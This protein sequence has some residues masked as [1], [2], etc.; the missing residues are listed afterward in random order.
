MM[1]TLLIAIGNRLR[2]DDGVAHQ[3]VALLALPRC[4]QVHSVHQLTPELGEEIAGFDEVVFVDAASSETQNPSVEELG[5]GPVCPTLGHAVSPSAVVTLA[6]RLYGF[7]GRVWVCSIPVADF[8]AG[9]ELS[10]AAAATAAR[11]ALV[12]QVFLEAGR[13]G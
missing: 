9:E 1:T 4:V 11:A 10:P 6:R 12:L 3:A 5:E 13:A 7:R 8:G 2:R